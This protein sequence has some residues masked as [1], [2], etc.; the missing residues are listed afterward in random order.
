MYVDDM[1][2]RYGRMVMCHM[3]ADTEEEL[4]GM[5][6]RI[7]VKRHWYQRFHYDICLAKR[8]KAIELGAIEVTVVEAA[9]RRRQLAIAALKK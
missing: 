1:M 5:A 9:K 8:R 7:G 6:A 4:H 2:A 3:L